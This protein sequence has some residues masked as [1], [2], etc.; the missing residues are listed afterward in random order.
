M[1]FGQSLP[2]LKMVIHLLNRQIKDSC[3]P[4]SDSINDK[5]KDLLSLIDNTIGTVRRIAT[6]LRPP[7]LD[8]LKSGGMILNFK[9]TASR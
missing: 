4:G 7:I 3:H 6:E 8:D 2:G 9:V 5:I 1:N